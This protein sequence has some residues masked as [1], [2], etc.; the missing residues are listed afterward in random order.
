MSFHMQ[1]LL[2]LTEFD[3]MRFN[4]LKSGQ[5]LLIRMHQEHELYILFQSP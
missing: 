3:D 2:V 4:P 5:R 1:E